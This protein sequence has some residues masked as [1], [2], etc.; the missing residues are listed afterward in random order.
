MSAAIAAGL[1]AD[2][3]EA[4]SSMVT[5]DQVVEPDAAN[6]EVYDQLFDRYIETYHAL[7]DAP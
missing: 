6:A 2:F 5:V 3:G 1:F 7:N 4:A